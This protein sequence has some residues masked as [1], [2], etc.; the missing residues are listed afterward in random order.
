MVVAAS[1]SRVKQSPRVRSFALKL[2]ARGKPRE[3]DGRDVNERETSSF[4][5]SCL[6]RD[7]LFVAVTRGLLRNDDKRASPFEHGLTTDR[8]NFIEAKCDSS[9][10][11]HTANLTQ[12]DFARPFRVARYLA[13][14][15]LTFFALAQL[16]LTDIIILSNFSFFSSSFLTLSSF[17]PRFFP[18]RIGYTYS[19][20]HRMS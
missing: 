6:A 11:V 14:P 9:P 13:L 4:F 17:V 2:D 19:R 15:Y 1:C 18:L 16:A 5:F 7:F 3:V 8:T 10:F 20:L 12:L